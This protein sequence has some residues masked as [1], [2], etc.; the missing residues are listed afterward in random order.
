MTQ[1]DTSLWQQALARK[2]RESEDNRKT[3]LQRVLDIVVT[4]FSGREVSAVYLCGSLLRPGA[5]DERSDIDI[6]VAG[7]SQESRRV[8][9]ELEELLGREVDL[10]ELE[11]CRFRAQIEQEGRRVL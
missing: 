2:K 9:A 11:N 7:L 8:A 6:A 5:F 4:Y 10:I 3:T 1:F